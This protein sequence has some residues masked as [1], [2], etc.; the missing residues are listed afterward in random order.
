MKANQ[1]LIN[2]FQKLMGDNRPRLLK[3]LNETFLYDFKKLSEWQFNKVKYLL[4]YSY[5]HVPFYK[6]WFDLHGVN[7]HEVKDFADYASKIPVLTKSD[8]L[9][10]ID[11]FSNLGPEKGAK[12]IHQST[13]G[14]TGQTLRFKMSQVDHETG[15]ALLL[16]G[17]GHAGY[18]LGDRLLVLAGGSLVSGKTSIKSKLVNKLFGQYRISSYGLQESDFEKIADLIISEQIKYLRG[19]ASALY[20]FADYCKSVNREIFLNAVFSTSEILLDNQRLLIEATFGCRVFNQYGLNDGGV[21]AFQFT[22]DDSLVIDMERGYMEIN[23]QQAPEDHNSKAGA[24][25]A[26]SFLNFEFPFI[27]YDTGDIGEIS[28]Q[29][30]GSFPDR[31]RLIKLLGRETEFL[32]LNG[33]K[34]ASPVLTVLMGKTNAEQYT[35]VQKGPSLVQVSI[36]KGVGY[37]KGDEIFIRK[38]L[39]EHCGEFDLDFQYV[40]KFSN[41]NKHKFIIREW[42]PL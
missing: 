32:Q 12:I 40:E 36:K 18:T 42:N 14:S 38:S 33:K 20:L 27:R 25:L 19:Y 9:K 29:Y 39:F 21:S 35:I 22:D 6:T 13:G 5:K 10:N 17:M 37:N 15:T 28:S 34:V 31:P 8:I 16:R 2:V 26:T 1:I 7:V 3:E 24:I 11:S 30:I 41:K 23:Q 4:D